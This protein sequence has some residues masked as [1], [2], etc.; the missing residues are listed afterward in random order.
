MLRG[1]VLGRP[2]EYITA[3]VVDWGAEDQ[4]AG[5]DYLLGKGVDLFLPGY[6]LDPSFMD[7]FAAQE[8][9]GIPYL[10][11]G[12]TELFAE[13]WASD[14][15]KYWNILQID[16]TSV[17]YS[18]NIYE[19]M[20]KA[21]SK[22]YDYPNKTVAILTSQITYNLEISAGLR[23][24]IE[25]DPEWEVVVDEEHPFGTQEFGVQLSKIR[26]TNPG[27]IFFSTVIVPE[28]VAFVRQFLQNPSD[29]LVVIHYCPSNVEFRKMLD[30]QA[31]GIL[32]QCSEGPP[33]THKVFEYRE[34]YIDKFGEEPGF[35][36]AYSVHDAVMFWAQAV[37]AVG[38]VKDYQGIIDYFMRTDIGAED[39]VIMAGMTQGPNGLSVSPLSGTD[40]TVWR[41]GMPQWDREN[42]PEGKDTGTSMSFSQIKMTSDGPQDVITYLYDIPVEEYML[43]YYGYLPQHKYVDEVGTE[44]VLPPW[45]D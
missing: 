39:R 35:C 8:T 41:V 45:L 14:P 27:F 4:V 16:D 42:R 9:G 3:D 1:G 32:W 44:F 23:D 7:I 19:V 12:T 36:Q 28:G 30:E 17:T 20:T 2:V 22:E 26:D 21:I 15:D 11:Y 10:H 18:P 38:D 31:L 37:E 34:R 24:L 5:R 6:G 43:E 33:P 13:M 40:R 29:S 25:A